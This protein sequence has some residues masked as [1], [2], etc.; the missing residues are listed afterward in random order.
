MPRAA[1][2]RDL[3]PPAPVPL[4]LVPPAPG[5]QVPAVLALVRLAPVP[6][7]LPGLTRVR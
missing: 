2:A 7:G 5:A 3:V 6:L 1:A 4:P